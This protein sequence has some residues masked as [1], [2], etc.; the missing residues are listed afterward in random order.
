MPKKKPQVESD[1]DALARREFVKCFALA[2]A[3]LAAAGAAGPAAADQ[4]GAGKVKHFIRDVTGA[5]IFDLSSPWDEFS[6]IASVN[7]PYNSSLVSTHAGT[8]GQFG[9]GGQL[10]FAAESQVWSGQHGAPSIDAI[11]HIGR[12]GKLFGGVDAAAAT[13]DTRGIGRNGVG[14]NLDIDH[15]PTGILVNRGVMLDV[16]RFVNGDLKPLPP[17]FEITAKHLSD[18]AKAHGVDLERGDTVLIRTGWGK[19]FRENPSLYRGDNSPGP[20]VDGAQFLIRAGARVVGDDTL[21]FEQRPP[22]TGTPGTPSFQVFPVHMLLI[23][24]HGINIVENYYLEELAEARVYEFVI[25]VPPLRLRGG[26]GSA[27]RSFALVPR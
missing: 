2:A 11:G 15:Y 21:T 13:A 3:G 9:D 27:I 5:R 7:P 1:A 8:R 26:T 23:A 14:A 19:Y 6:P 4:P 25:V 12:N 22:V 20:G 16:A 10:S 24:D 18:T 17:T